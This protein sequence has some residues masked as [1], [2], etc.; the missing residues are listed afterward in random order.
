M[1]RRLDDGL[2]PGERYDLS[3]HGKTVRARWR[4][5]NKK[6]MEANRNAHR[7]RMRARR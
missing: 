6:K 7:K 5:R 1:K 4:R 2:T 3:E